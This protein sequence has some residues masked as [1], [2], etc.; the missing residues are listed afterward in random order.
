MRTINKILL[1]GALVGGSALGFAATKPGKAFR[2]KVAAVA[3]DLYK[4]LEKTVDNLKEYSQDQYED[5][6][7]TVVSAYASQKKLASDV[8]KAL[9]KELMKKRAYAR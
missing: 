6:V 1:T 8:V 9:K 3:S 7:E 4:Y 5:L 2:K